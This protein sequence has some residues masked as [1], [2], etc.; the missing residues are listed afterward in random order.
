M[1]SGLD[2][3]ETPIRSSWSLLAF[4]ILVSAAYIVLYILALWK[5]GWDLENIN[6]NPLVGPN[7]AALAQF[8]S[9]V[10]SRVQQQNQWWRVPSSLF[11]SSGEQQL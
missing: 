1:H 6:V 10:N 4:R 7:R 2:S 8:G 9:L 3:P 5:A 11:V